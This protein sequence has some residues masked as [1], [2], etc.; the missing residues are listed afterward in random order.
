MAD[1]EGRR[2]DAKVEAAIDRAMRHGMMG[3]CAICGDET[4]GRES[5]EVADY[6][7]PRW[8]CKICQR[9]MADPGD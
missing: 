3:Y 2:E 6:Y 9:M 7:P 4:F 5:E 8:I 1:D